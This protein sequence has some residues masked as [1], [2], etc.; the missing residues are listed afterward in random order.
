MKHSPITKEIQTRRG[1]ANA[2]GAYNGAYYWEYDGIRLS[3]I[4]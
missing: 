3:D 1:K 4:L 2:S